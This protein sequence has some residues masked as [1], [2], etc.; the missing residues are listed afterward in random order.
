MKKFLLLIA[1]FSAVCS[2]SAIKLS[3]FINDTEIKAGETVK[4]SDIKVVSEDDYVEVTMAPALYL[5]S[6]IFSDEV[7]VTAA[8]TSGQSISLCAGGVCKGGETV[9]KEGVTVRANEKL[10]L[11]FDFIGEFDTEEEIPVVVTSIEAEDV[12]EE[13]SK[14]QFVIEMGKDV[15]AVTAIELSDDFKA[16]E[17][18][19]AYKADGATALTITALNGVT[20]CSATVEGEG[21][22]SLA[23]GLYVYTFGDKSGKIYIK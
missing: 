4:F 7:K 21:F 23:A 1:C 15:A 11:G 8:C 14:V 12:S 2:A 16:V 17:G 5:V 6:D 19:V 18:G 22:I 20:L 3:F 9:V 10:E 13:G